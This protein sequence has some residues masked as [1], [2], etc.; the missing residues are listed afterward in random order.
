MGLLNL[1]TRSQYWLESVMLFVL[2]HLQVLV[3]I[4][5]FHL[6]DKKPCAIFSVN[7]S[8]EPFLSDRGHD[9]DRDDDD[10]PFVYFAF[11]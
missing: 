7:I 1:V 5:P 11:Q 2:K 9:H 3:N 10:L 4:L 8:Y 6:V